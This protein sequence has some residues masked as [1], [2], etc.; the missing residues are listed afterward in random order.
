M[1]YII[2]KQ[3]IKL[4]KH[5]LCFCGEKETE[6]RGL[7]SFKAIRRKRPFCLGK[8]LHFHEL[9]ANDQTRGNIPD[10]VRAVSV[11]RTHFD[12]QSHTHHNF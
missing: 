11:S 6:R 1:S 5:Y 10:E 8:L 7:R 4:A 3:A 9:N 12:W 2:I